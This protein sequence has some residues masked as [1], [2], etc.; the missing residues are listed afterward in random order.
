MLQLK[1]VHLKG[2]E[3]AIKTFQDRVHRSNIKNK[4]TKIKIDA[5]QL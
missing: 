5:M 2:G 4:Y 1:I 3:N